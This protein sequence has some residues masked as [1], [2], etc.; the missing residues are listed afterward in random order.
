VIP[1]GKDIYITYVNKARKIY[2][3]NKSK[4][5]STT[6]IA[7]VFGEER[8]NSALFDYCGCVVKLEL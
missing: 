2:N 6:A 8:Q 1:C 7:R 3:L 5:K 4:M